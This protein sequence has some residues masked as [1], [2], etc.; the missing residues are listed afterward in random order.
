MRSQSILRRVHEGF[1]ELGE[2]G[3]ELGSSFSLRLAS[4]LTAPARGE[5]APESFQAAR[6]LTTGERIY[7]ASASLRDGTQG[8][9]MGSVYI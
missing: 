6:C 4:H 1:G 5:S 7:A 9:T 8:T 2:S 3:S